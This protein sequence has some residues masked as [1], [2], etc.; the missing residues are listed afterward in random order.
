[1]RRFWVFSLV[2]VGLV[3]L[4]SLSHQLTS[5]DEASLFMWE[6]H[7]AYWLLWALATPLILA[8]RRAAPFERNRLRRAFFVHT[9]TF[10]VVA[11]T[12]TALCLLVLYHGVKAVE[13]TVDA[14]GWAQVFWQTLDNRALAALPVYSVIVCVGQALEYRARLKERTLQAARLETELA[15]AELRGLKMQ[16]Q[17]HFLFNALHAVS[18]LIDEDPQAASKTLSK[19]G[20]LLRHSLQRMKGQEVTLQQELEFV[21][22][23]LQI[24]KVRFGNRLQV[25]I[26]APADVR[27][28][29]VPPFVLQPLVENSIRHGI[30]PHIE[31]GRV[32]LHAQRC[33]KDLQVTVRDRN[34]NDLHPNAP[35]SRG[36]GVGLRL[37]RERLDKMYGAQQSLQYRSSAE[38]TD[39]VVRLPFRKEP[40]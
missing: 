14:F 35:T 26:D 22:L 2:W 38:G 28:A 31:G 6:Y 7:S 15:R 3:V 5:P 17:P 33:G 39:V 32:Q 11:T 18:V 8:L 12:H 24:E 23:Y 34:R 19:I 25:D 16:L 36:T 40:H 37:T 29:C 27:L 21:D 13:R 30:E 1:M 10:C 4:A 9:L 20:D